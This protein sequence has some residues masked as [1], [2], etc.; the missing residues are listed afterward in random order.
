MDVIKN[1]YVEFPKYSA[2]CGCGVAFLV[3][4]VTAVVKRPPL[5]CGNKNLRK[6]IV[7]N[8][9]SVQEYYWPTIWCFE[10]RIMT[11]FASM[12]RQGFPD[13]KYRRE[14]L[15]MPDGG[16][17]GLDWLEHP[18]EETS[19]NRPITLFLPGLTGHS[20][21]IYMKAL[22]EES[23]NA[24]YRPVVIINRGLA[25][26][27]LLTTRIYCGADTKDLRLILDHLKELNPSTPIIAAGVSLGG[28]ILARYLVETGEHSKISAAMVI[29]ACFDLNEGAK[30]LEIPWFNLLF[31]RILTN[32]CVDIVK[33]HSEM[34]SQ[35]KNFNINNVVKSQTLRQFDDHFTSKMF[36]FGSAEKYYTEAS[37]RGRLRS[38][39]VPL[40]LLNAADDI[41]SPGYTL[42][43]RE[44][45][46]STHV[47]MV[48][49]S[50]GGHIGFMDSFIP[51][52]RMYSERLFREYVEG[53]AIQFKNPSSLHTF[54]SLITRT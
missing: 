34:L 5:F 13:L 12:I 18:T 37:L 36:D 21:S 51:I 25:G 1:V 9:P 49:T 52:G 35:H 33:D 14:I 43:Y 22:V 50:H 7:K 28:I 39:K 24:G 42:P 53:L 26:V 38:I 11:Y 32:M 23:Y 41:F 30:S 47:A 54:S 17:V 15:P 31:N 45:E 2:V 19:G 44:I 6:F 46:D 3:Y 29:S 48:I 10:S 4:Y 20:Q 40:L 27:E 8:C 16:Q